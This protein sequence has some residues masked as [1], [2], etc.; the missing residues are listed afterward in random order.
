[1][2]TPIALM[3]AP[4]RSAVPTTLPL[5]ATTVTCPLPPAAQPTTTVPSPPTA[6]SV[7]TGAPPESPIPIGSANTF[8]ALPR[9]SSARLPEP[10]TTSERPP[11]TP[12][13]GTELAGVVLGPGLGITTVGADQCGAA[14]AATGTAA[15][16]LTARA[17]AR[18]SFMTCQRCARAKVAREVSVRRP[19]RPT[20]AAPDP[21]RDPR[22]PPTPRAC[23]RAGSA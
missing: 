13:W 8:A 3:P 22:P 9:T 2:P 11:P 7:P 6:L 17:T 23:A 19:R 5:G 21:N 18:D 20:S 12:T 15:A 1:M 14:E 16:P 4:G 10:A